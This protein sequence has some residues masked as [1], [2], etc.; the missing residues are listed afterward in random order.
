ME[1]L[2]E[3]SYEE[4]KGRIL[5][6]FFLIETLADTVPSAMVN[7]PAKGVRTTG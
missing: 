4:D 5:Y 2:R 7:F 1:G 3:V 6:I